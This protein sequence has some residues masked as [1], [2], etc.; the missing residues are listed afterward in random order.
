MHPVRLVYQEISDPSS[1]AFQEAYDLYDGEFPDS[2]KEPLAAFKKWLT[3]KAEGK[4]APDNYHLLAVRKVAKGP[5]VA[6]ASFHYVAAANIG[7][8]GY[9]VVAEA[10]R[11][12]GVGSQVFQEIK[13]I[14]KED[15]RNAGKDYPFGIFT[16][17]EWL[18]ADDTGTEDRLRFW[19]KQNTLPLD[20]DWRYPP[21]EKGKVSAKMYLAF[22]PFSK[23]DYLD[24]AEAS[25]VV[26]A[27]Y[28][29]IYSKDETDPDLQY[30][31]QSIKSRG[32][33]AVGRRK[34]EDL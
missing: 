28:H 27:I 21:L 13:T 26:R 2:E 15:G 17:L 4:L 10:W 23:K 25:K 7:F 9:L 33:M 5:L 31:L 22:C 20:F 3:N 8:L 1:P 34:L 24:I 6:I 19:S 29:S 30:V 18:D 16:E 11:G 32:K 12:A 14:L